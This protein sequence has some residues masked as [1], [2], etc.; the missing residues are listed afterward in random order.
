[1]DWSLILHLL[2]FYFF[3]FSLLRHLQLTVGRVGPFIFSFFLREVPVGYNRL[4]VFFSNKVF[5]KFQQRSTIYKASLV[6]VSLACV[7]R[8]SRGVRP[9]LV[10]GVVY[11]IWEDHFRMR[12]QSEEFSYGLWSGYAFF[13]LDLAG[14]CFSFE[15]WAVPWEGL[16]VRFEV[17]AFEIGTGA[18]IFNVSEVAAPR[19][20]RFCST[21]SVHCVPTFKTILAVHWSFIIFLSISFCLL[22]YDF[23]ESQW[24][25]SFVGQ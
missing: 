15:F 17:V 8:S 24:L 1:M 18:H 20:R 10:I 5:V 22:T 6:W 3:V 16:V 7:L 25:F 4:V 9:S 13:S 2:I 12:N 23:Y 14:F 21:A 11:C 19:T